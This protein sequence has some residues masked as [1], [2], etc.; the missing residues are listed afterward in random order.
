MPRVD[1][2]LRNTLRLEQSYAD[3]VGV[4]K[5]LTT[6][7]VR[8]PEPSGLRSG[9]S[10]SRVQADMCRDAGFLGPYSDNALLEGCLTSRFDIF[11]ISFPV[12]SWNEW[13][14]VEMRFDLRE[15]FGD[16]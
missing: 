7:P 2:H 6:V 14:N 10:R 12:Q 16:S 8:K 4:K 1:G 9:R 11:P 13:R 5:L 3:T 15:L